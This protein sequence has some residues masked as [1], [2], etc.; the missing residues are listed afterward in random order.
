VTGHRAITPHAAFIDCR[1]GA[2]L[3]LMESA[4]VSVRVRELAA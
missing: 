1:E 2:Q 3:P 4:G